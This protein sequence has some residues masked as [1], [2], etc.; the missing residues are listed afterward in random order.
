MGSRTHARIAWVPPLRGLL[1]ELGL[2]PAL[3]CWALPYAA[4]SRLVCN[5][6]GLVF[7]T[8]DLIGMHASLVKHSRDTS[9]LVP[10][11]GG[12]VYDLQGRRRI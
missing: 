1:L 8:A 3:P 4:A 2:F 7:E 10:Q 12:T 6:A 5:V 9:L 11:A